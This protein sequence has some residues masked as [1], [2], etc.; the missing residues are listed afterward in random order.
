MICR[1]FWTFFFRYKISQ[2]S[3][4]KVYLWTF[5]VKVILKRLCKGSAR[6][7]LWQ[8]LACR[9]LICLNNNS[10]FRVCV[11]IFYVLLKCVFTEGR[12]FRVLKP[13]QQSIAACRWSK[14]GEALSMFFCQRKDAKY[15]ILDCDCVFA[16]LVGTSLQI[17]FLYLFIWDH[18]PQSQLQNTWLVFICMQ[19]LRDSEQ[20]QRGT[21]SFKIRAATQERDALWEVDSVIHFFSS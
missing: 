20:T 3:S 16:A 4:L 19:I 12:T 7:H 6:H 2:N 17:L 10:L 8:V 11:I 15:S 14:R 21:K 18:R 13:A 1:S 5:C 9:L